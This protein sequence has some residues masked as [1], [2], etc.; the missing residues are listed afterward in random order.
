MT[1]VPTMNVDDIDLS[2]MAFWALPW[3]ERERAFALLRAERPLAYFEEPDLSITSALAPPRGRGYRAVTRH[4]DV[5]EV[6]RHALQCSERSDEPSKKSG[7]GRS[8]TEPVTTA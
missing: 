8:E 4:A 3:S 7:V 6:S 2:D 5:T 1:H